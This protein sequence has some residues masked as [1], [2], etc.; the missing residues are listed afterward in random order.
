MARRERQM[1]RVVDAHDKKKVFLGQRAWHMYLYTYMNE[2]IHGHGHHHPL[3]MLMFEH[4]LKPCLDV[5]VQRP[6]LCVNLVSS[7]RN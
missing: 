3:L 1:L 7:N 4:A 5:Y 2:H 6:P